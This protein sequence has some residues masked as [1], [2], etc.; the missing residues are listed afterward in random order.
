M[1]HQLEGEYRSAL[2][3]LDHNF[4][5]LKTSKCQDWSGLIVQMVTFNPCYNPLVCL[6]FAQM[7]FKLTGHLVNLRN[8]AIYVA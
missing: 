5:E 4:M 7:S 3:K 2:G 8:V 1:S 6:E